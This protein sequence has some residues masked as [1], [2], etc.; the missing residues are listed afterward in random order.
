MGCPHD[1][2]PDCSWKIV[3][4]CW[5]QSIAAI[6]GSEMTEVIAN[7]LGKAFTSHGFA[8][9]DTISMLLS[10]IVGVQSDF[11]FVP[12]FGDNKL[13]NIWIIHSKL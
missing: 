2:R 8:W 3:I 5:K 12:S 10:K 9:T 6:K 11:L 7:D 1:F 13:T 4:H